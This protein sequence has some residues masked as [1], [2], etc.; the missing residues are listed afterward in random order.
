MGD[1]KEQ[2]HKQAR[3]LAGELRRDAEIALRA[4]SVELSTSAG[5][6]DVEPTCLAS[7]GEGAAETATLGCGHGKALSPLS[8]AVRDK[9]RKSVEASL[10]R[11]A[12]GVDE[13]VAE[14]DVTTD[15]EG[16]GRQGQVEEADALAAAVAELV[17]GGGGAGTAVEAL[18][19]KPPRVSAGERLVVCG[20]CCACVCRAKTCGE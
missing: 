4:P 7:A 3:E 14:R 5:V 17:E 10:D 9:V 11:S 15:D 1:D 6:C 12:G 13:A 8:Q 20:I 19:W 2:Q 16:G 18:F